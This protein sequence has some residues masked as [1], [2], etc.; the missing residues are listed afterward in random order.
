MGSE[1]AVCVCFDT[2]EG[3]AQVFLSA[4]FNLMSS[5]MD[6]KQFT[7]FKGSFTAKEAF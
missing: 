1:V 7:L 2:R 5:W 3:K 4:A 6:I